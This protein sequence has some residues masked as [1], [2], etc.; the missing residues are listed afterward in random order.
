MARIIVCPVC[1]KEIES[2]SSM[3]S[4]TLTNHMKEHK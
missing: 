1:K 2:R 4:Q 3:A